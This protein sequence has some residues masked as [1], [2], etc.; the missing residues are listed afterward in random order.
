MV[1]LASVR[2]FKDFI[3]LFIAL[4]FSSLFVFNDFSE[5]LAVCQGRCYDLAVLAGII[6]LSSFIVHMVL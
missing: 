3:F 2:M 1:T 6:L 5:L 4:A